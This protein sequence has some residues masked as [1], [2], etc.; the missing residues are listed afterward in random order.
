MSITYNYKKGSEKNFPDDVISARF[1]IYKDKDTSG[2]EEVWTRTVKRP[3]EIAARTK[4]E[5]YFRD[6]GDKFEKECKA[7]LV[8]IKPTAGPTFVKYA[9]EV[10]E[11]NHKRNVLK[12]S[13]Y[14]R[15]K[16]MLQRLDDYFGEQKLED[17]TP[18]ALSDFYDALAQPGMNKRGSEVKGLSAKTIREHHNLISGV[19]REALADEEVNINKNPAS[20]VKLS[21][22]EKPDVVYYQH[23]D[24]EKIARVMETQPLKWQTFFE[25]AITTGCRRGEILG[26]KQENINFETG[27]CDIKST[28]L[29]DKGVGVYESTPKTKDS[30]RHIP[31]S[32]TV[33]DMIKALIAENE[34]QKAK[35]GEY[36]EDNSYIF[37]QADGK[38]MHP[39]SVT[40]YFKKLSKKEQKNDP[41]FPQIKPHAF[42]HTVASLL[43]ANDVDIVTVAEF[44]GHSSP[45][46]TEKI[47]AHVIDENKSKAHKFV[48]EYM[49]TLITDESSSEA[50]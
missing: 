6:E 26:L 4:L 5:K 40:D 12:E 35:V 28:L 7:G 1:R 29:V 25:V 19:F 30:A 48:S 21:K 45:V 9:T 39:D 18:K 22:A 42:R 2:K 46:V 38:P 47:Y 31:L 43:I 32:Q 36:W 49:Q 20:K 37:R 44:L 8:P 34:V 50:K 24:L 13:T 11:K 10:I 14:V 15:Y 3:P 16:A 17:V 27:I 33:L 41:S 23:E